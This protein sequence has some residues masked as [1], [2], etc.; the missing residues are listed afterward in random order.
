MGLIR[1][2]AD[3]AGSVLADQWLEYFYQ[4]TM[5]ENLL[6][7]KGQKRSTKRSANSRRSEN[8]ISNGSGIVINEGQCMIIVEQGKVM[9]VCAEPGKYTWNQSSEPSVFSVDLS[10]AIENTFKAFARRFAHG[11]DTAKDQRI[12]Y[13][14]IKELVNNKFGTSSPVPFRVVDANIGLDADISIRCN[15]VY[16]YKITNPLQF[17]VNVV[18]NVDHEY[19]RDKID[20]QLKTEFLGALQ[21]AFAKLSEMGLR[22]SAIP[23]HA[24]ELSNAI[25]AA[26]TQ[27]WEELRG[28]KVVSVAINAISATR[29]DEIMIK[30][31]QRTAVMR[32]Q[33]MAGA[34]LVNAHAEAMKTAAANDAGAMTGFLG[35]GMV[36]QAGNAI[37]QNHVSNPISQTMGAATQSGHLDWSC[38]CGVTNTGKFCSECGTPNPVAS[39]WVC[40]CGADNSGKFCSECGKAKVVEVIWICDCGVSNTGRFCFECGAKKKEA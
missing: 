13:I 37:M 23:G 11:G 31:L 4:D 5:P 22:Y 10:N 28:I 2:A 9:D 25:N 35:V 32:D 1:I 20:N 3:T 18:G 24:V 29:D 8:I 17:Y 7:S 30:E 34:M 39:K 26:L 38:S 19:T 27:K 14:N 15:G 6:V 16:S 21:P 33:N 36:Q 12:Y 40:S